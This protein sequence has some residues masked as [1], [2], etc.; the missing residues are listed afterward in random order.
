MGE[1][2]DFKFKFFVLIKQMP[3]N[4]S[5][6]DVEINKIAPPTHL[7]KNFD[8]FVKMEKIAN[9]FSLKGFGCNILFIFN[10]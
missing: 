8:E 4:K 2:Q 3:K 7:P 10:F 9:L 6:L 1:V 5:K